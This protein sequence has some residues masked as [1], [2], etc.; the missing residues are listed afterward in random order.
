M[1]LI[2]ALSCTIFNEAWIGIISSY[3]SQTLVCVTA[4]SS[5]RAFHLDSSGAG[6]R[7]LQLKQTQ[8]VVHRKLREPFEVFFVLF[9]FF[10]L[11]ECPVGVLWLPGYNIKGYFKTGWT[12]HLSK[13]W[14]NSCLKVQTILILCWQKAQLL[15]SGQ[16]NSTK[17]TPR[18]FDAVR[19]LT[20]RGSARVSSR[21][22]R[23][24]DVGG[25]VGRGG[26]SP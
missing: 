20:A 12:A 19:I 9:L 17:G 13:N 15:L 5:P 24:G 8:Q 26:E 1:S 23:L 10:N 18:A 14:E 2:T 21:K 25:G 4:T 16:Q 7:N 22:L 11:T 6:P 3:C